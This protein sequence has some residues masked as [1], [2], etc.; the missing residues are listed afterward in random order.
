[1]TEFIRKKVFLH[2]QAGGLADND[3]VATAA[4]RFRRRRSL[5]RVTHKCWLS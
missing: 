5:P 1:M 4:A 2:L 3:L